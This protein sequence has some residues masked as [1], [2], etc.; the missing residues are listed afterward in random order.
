MATLFKVEAISQMG[1]ITRAA[2]GALD[3]ST[4]RDFWGVIAKVRVSI[5]D[6]PA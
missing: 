5:V 4:L 1:C 3:R 6:G 2:C